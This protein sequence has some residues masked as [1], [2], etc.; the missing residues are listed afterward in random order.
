MNDFS[1]TQA[2][3]DDC[4]VCQQGNLFFV[5]NPANQSL[6]PFRG[7]VGPLS[8]P[9]L[10]MGE[11]ETLINTAPDTPNQVQLQVGPRRQT[12]L[13]GPDDF[14]QCV[15]PEQ[16][17]VRIG[18]AAMPAESPVAPADHFTPDPALVARSSGE[19]A[20]MVPVGRYSSARL[21][22]Q[23]GLIAAG[24]ETNALD[25]L[26]EATAHE[27]ADA[28]EA[29]NEHAITAIE[30]DSVPPPGGD[31]TRDV[32][33]LS[34]ADAIWLSETVQT[35]VKRIGGV[36]IRVGTIL[37]VAEH[38]AFLREMGLGRARFYT[39]A[40][41]TR[42]VAFRGNNRLRAMITGTR[43]GMGGLNGK[44][45]TILDAAF[46]TPA[47]NAAAAVRNL[48]SKAGV[49]GLVFVASVDIAAYYAQPAHER[50]LSDLIVDL[51]FNLSIAVVSAVIGAVVTGALIAAT[52]VAAPVVLFVAAGLFV[53]VMVGWAASEVIAATGLREG[54]KEAARNTQAPRDEVYN[55]MM[56]AP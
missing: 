7:F 25:A 1:T 16:L 37:A 6:P 53:S 15:A 14:G 35:Y 24:S 11:I 42:M 28:R 54:L 44:S 2:A 18:I 43:Y 29:A 5:G 56:T 46:R 34:D 39:M 23:M 51:G 47:G 36:A 20:D 13:R 21:P 27:Y 41:G 32:D 9:N 52:T 50:E 49:I 10:P 40:D 30:V 26:A 33:D 55:G 22:G 38:R 48:G 19:G 4:L 31:G 3:D 45:V 8:T 12:L 17:Q